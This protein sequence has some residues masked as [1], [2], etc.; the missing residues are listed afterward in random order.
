MAVS[1]K[2]QDGRATP[3]EAVLR[4]ILAVLVEERD[5]RLK[6]SDAKDV[7]KIELLLANAGMDKDEIAAV[8]GKTP[9][10]V[11]KVIE[12]RKVK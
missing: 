8:T 10:A 1:Y 3:I 11:R 4:A 2:E 12:R 5:A 9:D 7:T 6:A